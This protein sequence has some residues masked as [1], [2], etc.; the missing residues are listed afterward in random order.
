M[1][2]DLAEISDVPIIMFSAMD[3][4][5]N[6]VEGLE[7]GADDY[8]TKPFHFTEV[9]ARIRALLRTRELVGQIE[10]REERIRVAES[11]AEHVTAFADSLRTPLASLAT[12]AA[13]I[14]PLCDS[15]SEFVE[16]ALLEVTA[17][18]KRLEELDAAVDMLRSKAEEIKKA[19]TSLPALK[20]TISIRPEE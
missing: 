6:K 20:K 3:D 16:R 15:A 4:V 1:D 17:A 2:A 18:L 13:H 5:Q 19:E 12:E 14:L 10:R 11:I 9:L 8:I 7:L